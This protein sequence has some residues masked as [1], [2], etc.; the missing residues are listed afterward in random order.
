MHLSYWELQQFFN[1]SDLVVIGSGIVGINAAL[2]YKLSHPRHK[3]IILERGLLPSGAST[4]NAGFACFGSVSELLSDLESA[5]EKTVWDTVALRYK[6]LKKLRK[7]LGDTPIDYRNYGGF[8][9]FDEQAE[10]EKCMDAIP[11][12]NERAKAITQ[13][14]RTYAQNKKIILSSGLA[15]VKYCIENSK[16][17]QIDTGLMMK[18]LISLAW[19]NDIS[20]LNGVGVE[21]LSDGPSGCILLLSSGLEIKTK[22]VIV[23]TNGFAKE[24]LKKKDVQ[25]A[26]AQVLITNE[27]KGLKLKGAFHYEQGFY[28]FRNINNRVLFGGGRNLDIKGEE[29]SEPGLTPLIQ[30]KLEK[31]LSTI[32]LPGVDFTIEHRWS[33]IMGVGKEKKPIIEHVSENVVCAVRMGGMGVAIGSLVGEMAVKELTK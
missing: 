5:D 15:K 3:V 4:K 17:G 23:A 31:M 20:I 28:Y 30:K 32:I 1:K 8:E 13:N 25:P 18:N 19:K 22:N 26:R 27:I 10:F 7:L 33:G 24:L 29:T 12:F 11:A 16:E 21:K 14:K 6:G 2:Q 9:V